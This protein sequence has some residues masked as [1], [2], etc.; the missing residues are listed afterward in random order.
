MENRLSVKTQIVSEWVK[1][2]PLRITNRVLID[3]LA[4]KVASL[5]WKAKCTSN[6]T[7]YFICKSGI[8]L[9]LFAV[10]CEDW[11]IPCVLWPVSADKNNPTL[12][13]AF[14]FVTFF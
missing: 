10:L 8:C 12:F 13:I 6:K 9:F 7:Y 14:D 11:K 5:W 3:I 4:F 1:R 2:F